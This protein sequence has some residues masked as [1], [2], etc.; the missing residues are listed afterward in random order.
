MKR[1]I[2]VIATLVA[3]GGAAAFAAKIWLLPPAA[4]SA[5]L[6]SAHADK[7]AALLR[8]LDAG[9][10]DAA[11]ALFDDK[12]REALGGG[13]LAEV[14]E[15]LP[16]QL[17]AR[18]ALIGPRGES[19]AGRPIVTYR[20]EFPA[21]AL[22]ARISVDAEGRIDGFR[23]VPAQA[24]PAAPPAA[25]APYTEREFA[26]AG[27]GGTLTLPRGEGPFPA[28]VLVHGSGPHD[29]DQSIGPNKPFRDLAHGLAAEGIAVLRYTKRTQAE[30]QRYR[31][32]FTVAE[33]TLDDAVAAVAALRGASEIDPSRVFVLGHSLGGYLAPRIGKAA[34]ELAGLIVAAGTT[35][36]IETVVAQQVRFLAARDGTT[37]DEERRGIEAIDAQVAA[38]QAALAADAATLPEGATPL[39][40]VPLAYWRDL[41]GYDPVELAATLPQPLLILQGERDYQVTVAEDFARWEARFATDP[42]ATLKRYPALNHLFIAGEGAPNPDEYLK[43]G[44]VDAAVIDDIAGWVAAR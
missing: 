9:E 24:L 5:T 32:D 33:E 12:A 3:L 29:R 26:V 30:P 38:L 4:A 1:W 37:S 13:K 20:M 42:R 41:A 19:I 17:G 7:A 16:K 34:P 10:Y 11:L 21:M 28:V 15:A 25:D 44:Q 6:D 14:W 40:G 36:P 23:V 35:R 31:G 8:H 43:P 27:L 22:D 2:L 18:S 39:L